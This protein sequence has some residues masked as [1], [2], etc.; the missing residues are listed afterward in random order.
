MK[1]DTN[2]QFANQQNSL[3]FSKIVG[4][5]FQ[6]NDSQVFVSNQYLTLDPKEASK[7]SQNNVKAK[8][9][10]KIQRTSFEFQNEDTQSNINVG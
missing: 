3:M 1:N 9:L 7:V 6:N 8:L 5:E 10:I 2:T 4:R